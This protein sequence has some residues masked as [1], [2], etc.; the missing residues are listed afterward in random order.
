MS[1]SLD[2]L[3]NDLDKEFAPL[4]IDIGRTTVVLRNPLRLTK[5]ERHVVFDASK[6]MTSGELGDEDVEE[7]MELIRSVLSTSAADGKGEALV[8]A[9]GDDVALAMKIMQLWTE[10]T[11]PGEASNSP[12]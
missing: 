11:Q 8:K 3:R 1:Y 12:A 6:R 10:A 9:I 7:M 2:D 5:A 4:Q